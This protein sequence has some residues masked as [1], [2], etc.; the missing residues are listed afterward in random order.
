MTEPEHLTRCKTCD[1]LVS[2]VDDRGLCEFCV[3]LERENEIEWN[4]GANDRY[5]SDGRD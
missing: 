5:R 3:E 2:T 4:R 1:G